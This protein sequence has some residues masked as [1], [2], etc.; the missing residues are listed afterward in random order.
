[1]TSRFPPG[2]LVA[3]SAVALT[4]GALMAA[5]AWAHMA[6]LAAYGVICGSAVGLAHCPACYGAAALFMLGFSALGLATRRRPS[7]ARS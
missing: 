3:L 1:M 6:S 5:L 7:P 4:G 2:G